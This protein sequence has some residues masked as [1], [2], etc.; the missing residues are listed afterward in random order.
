ML[1]TTAFTLAALGTLVSTSALARSSSPFEMAGF[2]SCRDEIRQDLGNASRGATFARVYYLADTDEGRRYFINYSA[3]E[4][5]D[6]VALR[7][8]CDTTRNGRNVLALNTDY[9]R[10]GVSRGKVT[11]DVA[12]R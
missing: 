10:Y 5:G 4:D 3:W 6:R 1:K 9:G 8:E 7:S 2:D 12:S 11:I